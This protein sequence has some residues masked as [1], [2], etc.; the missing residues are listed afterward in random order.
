MKEGICP[1]CAGHHIYSS[2]NLSGSH[3]E[4]KITP[5]LSSLRVLGLNVYICS[6]CLYIEEYVDE[7]NKHLIQ[8]LEKIKAN[9]EKI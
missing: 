4:R 6:D 9:W 1:K 3:G 2:R 5:T 7:D 8:G